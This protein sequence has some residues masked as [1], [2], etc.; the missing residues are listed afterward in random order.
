[1]PI[2][3]AKVTF[4]SP[5]ITLN[6]RGKL[7]DLST[8]QVMGILNNTPDSFYDGGRHNS[9]SRLTGQ[10]KKMVD[11]GVDIIDI[12][13]YSSRPGAMEVDLQT[14][15]QRVIEALKA[16]QSVD[17]NLPVSVDTFRAPV[18]QAAISAGAHMINDISGGSLDPDMFETVAQM[19]VPYILMHMKGD[20]QSM[21]GL[22]EYQDLHKEMADYFVNKVA[23]LQALGV[24]DIIIDPGFG[25][26]KTTEQNYALV[27]NLDYFQMVNCPLMIGVSRKSM[28]YKPLNITPDEALNVTTALHA[29]A[30]AKGAKI[31]RVHDVAEARQTVELFKLINA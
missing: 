19:Q 29:L 18:A 2:L 6:L 24:N 25:F 17:D 30:L 27:K 15:Q 5:K 1:M 20:P 12:G 31:L 13:G 9:S 14:E 22:A 26:A 23:Q 3:E 8:P 7:L 4:F 16:V 11:E 28:I 10:V 21:T